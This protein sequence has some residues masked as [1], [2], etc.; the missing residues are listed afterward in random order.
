MWADVV[1]ETRV[2]WLSIF[3]KR[4]SDRG[5]DGAIANMKKLQDTVTTFDARELLTESITRK[6]A[7]LTSTISTAY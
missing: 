3:G 6:R 1:K 5:G 7:D 2:G 4:F